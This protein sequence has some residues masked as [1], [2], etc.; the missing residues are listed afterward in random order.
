MLKKTITTTL[1]LMSFFAVSV[2][3]VSASAPGFAE[4]GHS[5]VSQEAQKQNQEKSADDLA[6]NLLDELNL[7]C[8][9]NEKAGLWIEVGH[10]ELEEDPR[11]WLAF[12][13]IRATQFAKAYLSAKFKFITRTGVFPITVAAASGQMENAKKSWKIQIPSTEISTQYVGIENKLNEEF[14]KRILDL[15][16]TLKEL[17]L[18][19]K[20]LKERM[21]MAN[22]YRE[23]L[24]TLHQDAGVQIQVMSLP[25][26]GSFPVAQFESFLDRKYQVVVILA[27]PGK[28]NDKEKTGPLVPTK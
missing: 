11:N 10:A 2:G 15:H 9:W 24:E 27:W 20:S 19:E 25:L 17:G 1:L 3:V 14:D 28:L 6:F 23:G 16:D 21:D 5:I 8:G 18:N 22:L 26:P 7:I 13:R 4:E 12:K